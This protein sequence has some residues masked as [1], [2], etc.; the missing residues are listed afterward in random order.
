MPPRHFLTDVQ[1]LAFLRTVLADARRLTKQTQEVLAESERLLDLADKIG[2]PRIAG[3]NEGVTD[4][5]QS[6]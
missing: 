1:T 6:D 3:T 2:A 4:R 5:T